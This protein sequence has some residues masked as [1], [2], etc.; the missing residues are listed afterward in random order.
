MLPSWYQYQLVTLLP[1]VDKS[2]GP[3]GA[4][5]CVSYNIMFR[6]ILLQYANIQCLPFKGSATVA[7]NS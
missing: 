2:V 1:K 6:V 3:D 4:L 5:R 7:S